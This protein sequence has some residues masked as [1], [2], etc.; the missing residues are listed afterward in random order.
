MI[1][2]QNPKYFKIIPKRDKIKLPISFRDDIQ[3]GTDK[4]EEGATK[5]N[6]FRQD[7]APTGGMREGDLWYDT[8]DNNK[9]YRYE[10][11]SWTEVRP[12]AE[13]VT[14][15]RNFEAVVDAA[16]TGDYTDIQSALDA[17][18]KR[19]FV[20]GGTYSLTADIIL[21]NDVLIQGESKYNTIIDLNGDHRIKA[22]GDTP[23]MV[24]T[25][26]VTNGS[27][28]VTGS[29]TAWSSNLVAGDFIIFNGNSYK[30][31]SVD[32]D[33]SLTIDITYTGKSESGISYKAGTFKNNIHIKNVKIT[34]QVPTA[35]T[36]AIYFY[37]VIRSGVDDCILTKNNSSYS[38]GL[39]LKYCYNNSFSKVNANN[40]GEYGIWAEYSDNNSFTD[41]NVNNNRYEGININYANNNF[42]RGV[43]ANSNEDGIQLVSSD[44]NILEQIDCNENKS[45]GFSVGGNNNLFSGI[46]ANNNG[47]YGFA[48]INASSGN[49]IR[50]IQ[51]SE[52]SSYNIY[53]NTADNNVIIGIDTADASSSTPSIYLDHSDNNIIS[54]SRVNG[55]GV[56]LY[57][58]NHN[59][60]DCDIKNSNNRGIYLRASSVNRIRANLKNNCQSADDIWDEIGIRNDGVNFS[61]KNRISATIYE[62]ASNRA[63]YGI[64]EYAPSTW[65][66]GTA[67]SLNNLVI[68]TSGNGYVYK[69][70][71][72]GTSGSSEPTWPTTVGDTVTDGGVTWECVRGND[73]NLIHDCIV[74]G[75]KTGSIFIY[76]GESIEVD[77]III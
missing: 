2:D 8:N 49:I 6:V 60:I 44:G 40:N 50:G 39:W 16:G 64:K 51:A 4:P 38:T 25:I 67:Y 7:T 68:P 37:G 31:A 69:C 47:E 1:I 28:T 54:A 36:G 57:Y 65:F 15:A 75:A 24:G 33:T 70:T 35:L 55:R 56:E 58:S 18:N 76:G 59:S 48:L 14:G 62:D 23:Y 73:Y 9:C 20:R 22:V 61:S 66:S 45:D 12:V 3:L 77:N 71:V 27:T 32:S 63:K 46:N 19:I 41:I 42:L 30:I 10:N 11:E 26:A 43:T 52:N 5:R 34:G 29:G 17:G 21:D 13:N 72:S 53:F 74:E